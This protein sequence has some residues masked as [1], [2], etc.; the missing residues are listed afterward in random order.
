MQLPGAEGPSVTEGFYKLTAT[1]D[2]RG[3]RLCAEGLVLGAQPIWFSDHVYP[4]AKEALAS[5]EFLGD[6]GPRKSW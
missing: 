3:Y 2:E 5:P 1:K 4:T 6:R